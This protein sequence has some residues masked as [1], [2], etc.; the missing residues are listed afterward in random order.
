MV[1]ENSLREEAPLVKKSLIQLEKMEQEL[2]PGGK[3][4]GA[5]SNG[6]SCWTRQGISRKIRK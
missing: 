6:G 1:V 4:S 3:G 2:H 5:S